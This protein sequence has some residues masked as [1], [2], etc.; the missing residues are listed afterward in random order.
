MNTAEPRILIID[1]QPDSIALLLRYFEGQP[2][3]V[4]I[5]VSG[6][7]G[8]RRV[9]DA[10]PDVVLLDVAMPGMD[11]FEVCRRL[12]SDPRSAAIPV[13][14][15]SANSS[16][17]HRLT[18]FSVGAADFV[19]KPFSAEEVLTRSFVH[20]RHKREVQKL[21]TLGIQSISDSQREQPAREKRIVLDAI[22]ELRRDTAQ[23]E[24][25]AGLARKVGTN[26]KKLTEL[27]R[28][29]FGKT[30]YEYLIELRLESAR[31]HLSNSALQIQLIAERAGYR[32]PSD[33]SRAFRTRYG[34]GPRQYRKASGQSE[35]VGHG[36][37]ADD[38]D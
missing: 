25:L 21:V 28:I 27:F 35:S 36:E 13:I 15:L 9:R 32:N 14:F 31:W 8:L 10:P 22:A 2:L 38:N 12:K 16:L 19:G 6:E 7:D 29:Q 23:W 24:G 26:E 37:T 30:V 33:F 1:D 20:I 5:A 34:L 18:G 17:D 4:M 3:D 11:G